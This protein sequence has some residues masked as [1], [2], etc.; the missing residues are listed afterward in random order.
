MTQRI[1]LIS[2]HR[3]L[4]CSLTKGNKSLKFELCFLFL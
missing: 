3:V 1:I 4:E 2:F